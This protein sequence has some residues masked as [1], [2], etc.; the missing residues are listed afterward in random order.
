MKLI[1]GTSVT[2]RYQIIVVIFQEGLKEDGGGGGGGNPN[3]ISQ[4]TSSNRWSKQMPPHS[5]TH[6]FLF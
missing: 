4:P 5:Y 1:A 6:I 2:G 3:P